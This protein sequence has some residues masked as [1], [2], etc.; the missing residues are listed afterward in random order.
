MKSLAG[1][2]TERNSLNL[3]REANLRKID[4][5]HIS[6]DESNSTIKVLQ[7]VKVTQIEAKGV[8]NEEESSDLNKEENTIVKII[9]SNDQPSQDIKSIKEKRIEINER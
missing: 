6:L 9:E 3:E 1:L 7:K 5:L 2:E 4:L 8:L